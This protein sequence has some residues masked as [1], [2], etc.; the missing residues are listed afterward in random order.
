[1]Y[2]IVLFFGTDASDSKTDSDGVRSVRWPMP[3]RQ[4]VGSASTKIGKQRF[5][6]E[7]HCTVCSPAELEKSKSENPSSMR[8]NVLSS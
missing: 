3:S 4:W 5:G 7:A 1:M 8:K 6:R 2:Y